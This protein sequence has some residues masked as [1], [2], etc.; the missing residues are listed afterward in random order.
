[1]EY[2]SPRRLGQLVF[3]LQQIFQSEL[4]NFANV[5]DAEQ[6][7]ADSEVVA[8]VKAIVTDDETRLKKALEFR[9]TA[10]LLVK[11]N[12][13]GETSVAYLL[14]RMLETLGRQPLYGTSLDP[15]DG[16]RIEKIR[17]A[18]EIAKNGQIGVYRQTSGVH[19]FRRALGSH[20]A[21]FLAPLIKQ[22]TVYWDSAI[23]KGGVQL[24]DLP[25]IGIAG[26]VYRDVT[27][28]WI[29]ERANV[30]V[31]TVDR[32]G[33]TESAAELLRS[34]EF[35]NRL[36]WSVDDPR[37]N[38][39]LLIAV[40]QI[41]NVADEYFQQD[42]SRRRFEYFADVCAQFPERL[43]QQLREQLDA[44]WVGSNDGSAE[45]TKVIQ[46]VLQTC[47]VH[48][49][50]AVQYRRVL[51]NDE[52]DPAFIKSETQSNIPQLA[53]ALMTLARNREAERLR[54]LQERVLLLYSRLKA[55]IAVIKAQWLQ[56]DRAAQEAERL[57]GELANF[58]TPLREELRTRQGQF[59]E[60]LKETVPQQIEKLVLNAQNRARKQIMAYLDTLQD[61]H[62]ATLRAAVT[63]GGTFFGRRRINLPQDFGLTFEEPIA[64]VWSKSI[65]T[66]IRQ[67]T[68]QFADDCVELVEQV[69]TWA[70]AQG[71]RVK[72]ALLEAQRDA[73]V[74][75]AKNLTAVGREKVNELGEEVRNKL[76][77][78]ID[79]PIRSRCTA[80]VN[81]N[82]HIGP[83]VKLRILRLFSRLAEEVTEAA[84]QPATEILVK[85]Y[86]SVC[87]EINEVFEKWQDPLQAAADAIVSSQEDYLK[88]SDAQKRGRILAAV[89]VVEQGCPELPVG[90][91]RELDMDQ[92][93]PTP[94][95][96]NNTIG[97]A[98]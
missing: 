56:E 23:L 63:R 73:I 72:R 29:R 39:V 28:T 52:E 83:G 8:D 97:V 50:S 84:S 31:L 51:A 27:Q 9:K 54:G 80:F 82:S 53:E 78:H 58:L 65:L 66:V 61:A 77:R 6:L 16:P 37:G 98:G 48:P 60:F 13:D 90:W 67:R 71:A 17:E 1:M 22:L 86:Q 19:E 14:D 34:T 95:V 4:R 45:K 96:G 41:D 7:P 25:G 87:R 64:E 40:V 91:L 33:I 24:V 44:V 94:L 70:K 3:A 55:E 5:T 30:V 11:G 32:S 12:Q 46:N 21:G 49:V 74:A 76:I 89:D 35:L 2:H 75:D 68:K 20:A 85:L 15:A 10:H 42:R 81:E 79:G 38:P 36:L 57:R 62:W 92:P 88:R 47:Q 59:R 93:V 18:L 26:D 43:R 69:V